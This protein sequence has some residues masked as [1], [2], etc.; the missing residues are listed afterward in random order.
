MS[1]DER[2]SKLIE[3]QRG[4]INN[5][6]YANIKTK[7]EELDGWLRNRLRYCIWHH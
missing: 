1:F 4:W 2:I 3:I 5:F 6:K 7:L